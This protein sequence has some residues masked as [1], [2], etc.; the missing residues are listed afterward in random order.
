MTKE[1]RQLT[2]VL[3]CV[4]D[5][6]K[7]LLIK[8]NAPHAPL[9][10]NQWEFPGGKVEFGETPNKA[11]EREIFEETGQRVRAIE[12]LPFPY[13]AVRDFPNLQLHTIAFCFRCE[14]L[15][16]SPA[17]HTAEVLGAEWV[18][19]PQIDPL[20]IQSGTLHF[21]RH[22]LAAQNA[23]IQIPLASDATFSF[24]SLRSINPRENRRRG[25][26]VG[27]ESNLVS[28]D[29][30]VVQRCWGRLDGKMR[31]DSRSFSS[32]DDM[33]A[34]LEAIIKTRKL[35]HYEI[36]DASTNIPNIPSLVSIPRAADKQL[37]LFEERRSK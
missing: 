33:L 3:G 17:R 19:L 23:T 16:V 7:V 12:L 13:V 20:T 15:E 29:L 21:L 30:F 24:I 8:R 11:I 36:L 14:P 34:F 27:I 1:R 4:I 25:Y 31:S 18:D 26:F 28:E 37:R 2:V 35:H 5:G 32:R 10:H 9:L 6:I 22:I